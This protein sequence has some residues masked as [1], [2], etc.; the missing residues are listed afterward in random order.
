MKLYRG[1][2]SGHSVN[3]SA[4]KERSSH[5]CKWT[6]NKVPSV[7]FEFPDFNG[8]G[9][10]RNHRFVVIVDYD[11]VAKILWTLRDHDVSCKRLLDAWQERYE[12]DQDPDEIKRKLGLIA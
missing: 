6:S 5:L 1:P 10:L 12:L 9:L 8:P 11:D 2:A 7:Q 4:Q 3:T